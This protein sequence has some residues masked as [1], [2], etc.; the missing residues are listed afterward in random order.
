MKMVGVN[1]AP[2]RIRHSGRVGNSG[3]DTF[4]KKNGCYTLV[5]SEHPGFG[6]DP[7][8]GSDQKMGATLSFYI[9]VIGPIY[10]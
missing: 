2:V 9:S 10:S 3:R 6:S 5:V 8:I 4:E 1:R 7:P